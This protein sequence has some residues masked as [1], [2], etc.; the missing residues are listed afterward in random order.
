MAYKIS[1]TDF[2]KKRLEETDA[3]K[4]GESSRAESSRAEKYRNGMNEE[5]RTG[6]AEPLKIGA[7]ADA[8]L[9]D[10]G[11]LLKEAG[12]A[13]MSAELEKMRLNACRERF[14]IAVTGEFSR[15]KSTLINKLLNREFLPAGNLPTTAVLTRIRYN[16]R[17]VIMAFDEKNQKVFERKLSLESWEGLTAQNFGGED[18]RGTVLTGIASEWLRDSNIELMDTPGA[19]DLSESRAKVVGDALL[20]CDG[21][22]ITVSAASPLSLSEKLFI[23]ERLLARKL[24]FL[25]LAITKLDMIPI[26]ERAGVI[27]YIK[28]KLESWNM[29]IPVYVPYPVEMNETT[30]DNIMGLDKVRNEIYRWI[31]CRERTELTETW[32]LEKTSD[33]MGHAISSLSEKKLLLEERD[34]E[35]RNALL[36]DKK[37]KLAQA[38]LTWGELK[39]Q[40]NR[41]CTE[42]YQLLLTRVDDYA[43]NI[44]ERLQYEASHAGNPQKWWAE[45]FHY[46]VK[47]ELTNMA[48]GIENIVSRQIGEDARW[49]CAAIEKTF[50]SC[51]LYQKETIS[52]K[53]LFRNFDVGG[54]VK[55][56]NL[57]KQRNVF[58]IGSAVLSVS[59][60]ALFSALGFL[61]I[62]ATM[63]IG[64]GTAIFSEKF[65]RKKIE[66]QREEIKKEIA[67]CVPVFIQE[68]MAE[69]ESRLEAVYKNLIDEAEKSEKSWLELQKDAIKNSD[70]AEADKTYEVLTDHLEKLQK[71]ADTVLEMLKER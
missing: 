34:R 62:V 44:T 6:K 13:G 56:E 36:S 71:Q 45:D 63:G 31:T 46:R 2:F 7:A 52:D 40:M 59:G 16:P 70:T 66:E 22:I 9:R 1:N 23:E 29:D 24:P 41:K 48:V 58:K 19:G 32:L 60:F 51:I 42:C 47:I 26:E 67:R 37:Q 61:P 69:S 33:M 27:R 65:F 17:E 68:A 15:G 21:A 49:Y 10:S 43:E 64:T 30:Y 4:S 25:L 5:T 11:K 12:Y 50:H 39:L 54:K 57:D 28:D 55:L 38:Q 18:F 53:D 8:V 20:G 35:K 14:T 3:A